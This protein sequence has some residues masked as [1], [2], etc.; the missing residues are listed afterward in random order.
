MKTHLF[1]AHRNCNCRKK[2]KPVSFKLLRDCDCLFY[3]KHRIFGVKNGITSR[4]SEPAERRDVIND[5]QLIQK[6]ITILIDK[7]SG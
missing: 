7:K 4:L 6:R 5:R 1:C 3:R 2:V